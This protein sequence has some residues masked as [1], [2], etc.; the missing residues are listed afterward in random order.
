MDS[1]DRPVDLL[2]TV[3]D[4]FTALGAR[5]DTVEAIAALRRCGVDV[6]RPWRGGRRSYGGELSPR[7]VD[8]VRLLVGGLTNREIGDKLYLSPKT[9]ARHLDSAMRKRGVSSRTALAVRV[10][11]DGLV[12]NGGSKFGSAAQLNEAE[13]GPRLDPGGT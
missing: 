1:G 8:V 10:V 4:G 3:L 6:R 7:E 9:V 12:A 5:P 13:T 11:E 2:K